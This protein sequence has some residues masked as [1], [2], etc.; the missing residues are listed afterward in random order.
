MQEHHRGS[1]SGSAL[2]CCPQSISIINALEKGA[3][4]WELSQLGVKHSL[5][6]YSHWTTQT[7]TLL[8]DSLLSSVHRCSALMLLHPWD[9]PGKSTGVGCH[10]LLHREKKPLLIFFTP[11]LSLELRNR[12]NSYPQKMGSFLFWLPH[13]LFF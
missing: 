12:K 1:C 10:C 5:P 6:K 7:P 13:P 2:R 3:Q 8:V 4:E 9:F 11:S